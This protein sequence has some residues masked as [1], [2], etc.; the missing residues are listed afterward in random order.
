MTGKTDWISDGEIVISCT[1]GNKLLGEITGGGCLVGTSVAAF[2][3]AANLE[4]QSS[5]ERYLVRGDMLT[6][7]IAGY[8]FLPSLGFASVLTIFWAWCHA[9]IGILSILAITIASELAAAREDVKGSGTFLPAL[10]DELYNLT[11]E[12]I[13]D[14]ARIEVHL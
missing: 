6:G 8:G 10:I 4:G 2:C 1:N 11:P 14:K 7:T 13:M 5:V 9:R 3:A 12:T